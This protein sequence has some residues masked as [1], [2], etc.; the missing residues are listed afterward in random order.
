M[1]G[2][3][4]CKNEKTY[5]SGAVGHKVQKGETASKIAKEHKVSLDLMK[6]LN[7]KV[8]LD[9]VNVGDVLVFKA[10]KQNETQ[11][12]NPTPEAKP[13]TKPK[14][15]STAASFYQPKSLTASKEANQVAAKTGL[16]PKYIEEIMQSE[17]LSLTVYDCDANKKTIGFGHRVNGDKRFNSKSKITKDQATKLL[18]EDL[19][20]AKNDLKGAIGDTKLT[21]AQEEVLVD[22]VFN[23]GIGMIEGAPKLQKALKEGRMEDAA[24]ELDFIAV[25]ESEN[26][27]TIKRVSEGLCIRRLKNMEKFCSG[28]FS[29]KVTT[30]AEDIKIKMLGAYDRRFSLQTTNKNREYILSR[31]DSSELLTTELIKRC[32]QKYK[33]A[34]VETPEVKEKSTWQ[35]VKDWWHSW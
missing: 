6:E 10:A 13:E 29:P 35:K 16:S 2:P 25:T 26:G 9:K 4:N 3:E 24:C 19:L 21:T 18:S 33:P 28:E 20:K 27:I 11:T 12:K 8:D 5:Y 14:T 17:G 1:T 23:G 15:K 34:T 31:R 22:L 7:P 30:K 32:S